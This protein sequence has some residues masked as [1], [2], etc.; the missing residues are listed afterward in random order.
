MN[1][2]RELYDRV[3]GE[4]WSELPVFWGNDHSGRNEGM[5]DGAPFVAGMFRG[6]VPP[7]GS[8]SFSAIAPGTTIR[9]HCGPTNEMITCH[10]GLVIPEHE[11][12][13]EL[14]IV[15]GGEE[16]GWAAGEWICFEDSME[17]AAWNRSRGTRVVLIVQLKHP[18][19]R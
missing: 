15:A 9:P 7:S 14:G 6:V 19:M 11:S 10:L 17:H 5:A 12:I 2:D 1:Q 3:A 4:D 18:L 13:E 8:V 16:R